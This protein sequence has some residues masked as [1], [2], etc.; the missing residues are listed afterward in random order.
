[1]LGRHKRIAGV[2][3]AFIGAACGSAPTSPEDL[4]NLHLTPGEYLFV[5]SVLNPPPNCGPNFG[6]QDVAMSSRVTLN[7]EGSDWVARSTTTADGTLQFTFRGAPGPVIDSSSPVGG[8]VRGTAHHQDNANSSIK[9]SVTIPI[10][11]ESA[12]V[13]GWANDKS[14]VNTVF[15]TSSFTM[16]FQRT[17]DGATVT[18]SL[19]TNLWTLKRK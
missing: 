11:G 5:T 7:R 10:S 14:D 15:G 17:A 18:C 3:I 6:T 4:F 16:A 1:M 13:T 2:A 12:T 8:T 19:A 9:R